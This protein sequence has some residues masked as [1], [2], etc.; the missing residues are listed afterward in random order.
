M[1]S[2][3]K[4]SFSKQTFIELLAILIVAVFLGGLLTGCTAMAPQKEAEEQ[5]AEIGKATAAFLQRLEK[6][7]GG[8]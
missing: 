1:Q 5:T 7:Y 3:Y 2:T 8:L 4:Q 6:A